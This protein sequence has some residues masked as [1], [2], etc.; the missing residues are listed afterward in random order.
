MSA[1]S[2]LRNIRQADMV[3]AAAARTG[4]SVG[5]TPKQPP[6]TGARRGL[7]ETSLRTLNFEVP[8]TIDP[9]LEP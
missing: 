2:S 9:N 5:M 8:L 7:A 6:E 1:C 4:D 3:M